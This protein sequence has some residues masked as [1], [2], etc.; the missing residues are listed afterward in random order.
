MRILCVDDN[1]AILN[2]LEKMLPAALG[3]EVVTTVSSAQALTSIANG[4]LPDVILLDYMM[5]G[6]SG[7]E[8]CMGLKKNPLLSRACIVIHSAVGSSIKRAALNAGAYGVVDKPMK[9]IE[10][11]N[12]LHTLHKEFQS[13]APSPLIEQLNKPP[14]AATRGRLGVPPPGSPASR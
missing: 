10:L 13:G 11:A 6:T 2:L 12:A 14:V 3:A 1:V 5:P 7:V 8:L 4:F 9:M